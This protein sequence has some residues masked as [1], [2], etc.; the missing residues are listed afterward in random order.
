MM[1]KIITFCVGF[2]LLISAISFIA[3]SPSRTADENAEQGAELIEQAVTPWWSG[4][5]IW[6]GGLGTIGAVGIIVVFYF[7]DKS[8]SR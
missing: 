4:L 5:A 2:V 3:G 8:G 6:L 1:G 7:L